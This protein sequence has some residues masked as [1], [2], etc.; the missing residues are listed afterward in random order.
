LSSADRQRLFLNARLPDGGRGD[1]AICDG[2]FVDRRELGGAIEVVDLD[3]L[4]VLPGFV[5]SHIHLDKS[6]I[7]DRWR[8]HRAATSLNQ[9]LHIEKE[10]LADALPIADRADALL[11]QVRSLGTVALRSHV[12]VD[13]TVGLSNLHAVVEAKTRWRDRVE[14]EIVAFP[15]A[16]ILRS[17][18]TADL[19][20]AAIR[21]GATVIGGLDPTTFDGDADAHLDIVFGIAQRHGVKID[22]HLHEAGLQGAEQ[23]RRIAARTLAAGMSG[24]VAISHAYALG[25]V[26]EDDLARTAELL[27]KAEVS[28]MTNAP[29]DR[30]FPPVGFLRSAGVR[31]L[32]GSDNIR[33][34]WWPYGDGDMLGRTMMI[35]YRSGFGADEELEF[36]L[37]MATTASATALGLERYGLARGDEATFVILDAPNAAAAVAAPP[38]DRRLVQRGELQPAPPSR[39]NSLSPDLQNRQRSPS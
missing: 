37:E 23:I 2:L 13:A 24:K 5:D 36:A 25:D 17:P 26:G 28:I 39:L 14:I 35:S 9:R 6:L 29:G 21:E 8:P 19:L 34:A 4:L 11:A 20:D 38:A 22:I 18:G 3:G 1:L 7:G 30:A 31:V 27:A 12:D 32:A 16:G 15:Q 10:M 33:D